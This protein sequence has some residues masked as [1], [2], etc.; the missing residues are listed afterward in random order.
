MGAVMTEVMVALENL[1]KR[2]THAGE[3]HQR[4]LVSTFPR[5]TS[6]IL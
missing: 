2:N 4:K 1:T 5:D 6:I 3:S